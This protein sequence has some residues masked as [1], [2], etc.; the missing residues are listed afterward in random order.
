[1]HAGY[2]AHLADEQRTRRARFA[3][4]LNDHVPA[5]RRTTP[6]KGTEPESTA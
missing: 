2:L 4:H 3:R 5:N 6:E 1:M